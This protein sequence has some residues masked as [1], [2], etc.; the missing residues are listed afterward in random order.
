M[1]RLR[2]KLSRVV[3]ANA[4]MQANQDINVGGRFTRAQYQYTFDERGLR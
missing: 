2:P 3:G 4:A 1:N